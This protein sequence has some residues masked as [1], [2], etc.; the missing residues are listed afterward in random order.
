MELVLKLTLLAR[1]LRGGA[2]VSVACAE[3]G[4]RMF[5]C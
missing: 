4:V 5:P 2:L 1:A 3:E